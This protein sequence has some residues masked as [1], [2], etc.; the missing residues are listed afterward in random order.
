MVTA[1]KVE[2]AQS[3]KWLKKSG[4]QFPKLGPHFCRLHF[5]QALFGD[6]GEYFWIRRKKA[7]QVNNACAIYAQ[8]LMVACLIPLSFQHRE[9]RVHYRH[10]TIPDS[11]PGCL[12]SATTNRLQRLRPIKSWRKTLSVPHSPTPRI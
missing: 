9:P 5:T 12:M 8:P 3:G 1:Q 11:T 10:C 7:R 6:G 4:G 2:I